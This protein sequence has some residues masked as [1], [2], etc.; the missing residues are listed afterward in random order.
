MIE[1]DS[2]VASMRQNYIKLMAYVGYPSID[3]GEIE[4]ILNRFDVTFPDEINRFIKH[5]YDVSN[6]RSI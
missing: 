3:A 2:D 5:S 6:I 4:D 1:I